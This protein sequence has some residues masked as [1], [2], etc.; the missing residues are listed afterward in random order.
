MQPAAL[1]RV[2]GTFRARR[3][4]SQVPTRARLAPAAPQ[5]PLQS[6][7]VGKAC[8]WPSPAE[9]QQQLPAAGRPA[10]LALLLSGLELVLAKPA[11]SGSRGQ[12]RARQ[13]RK[14][15]APWLL[16]G[17]AQLLPRLLPSVAVA[18]SDVRLK[19]Q[20][21]ARAVQRGCWSRW[22]CWRCS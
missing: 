8:W 17:A 5:G 1:Q 7:A 9:R 18:A 21:G 4:N 22:S 15:P 16:Q 20:V 2:V 6:I 19:L 13:A 3:G 11:A 12:G 10:R 14:A